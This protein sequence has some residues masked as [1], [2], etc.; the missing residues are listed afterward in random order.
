[1][2]Y[3]RCVEKLSA[4]GR[5]ELFATRNGEH[6]TV[7]ALIT[8]GCDE[9]AKLAYAQYV[10]KPTQA[11]KS[12]FRTTQNVPNS[13]RLP[14]LMSSRQVNFYSDGEPSPPGLVAPKPNAMAPSM[15][16]K[17]Y[18]DVQSAAEVIDTKQ[19]QS[20]SEEYSSV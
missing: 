5:R 14:S 15:F 10:N 19:E 7:G 2:A 3:F 16:R 12:A 13:Q 17:R 1:M 11:L 8:E 4:V 20:S 6:K 18:T 9:K